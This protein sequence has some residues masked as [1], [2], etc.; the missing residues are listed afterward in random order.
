M[1]LA[2]NGLHFNE[3]RVLVTVAD[4]RGFGAAGQRL[5]LTQSAVSHSVRTAERKL[6]A[7]L[8]DRGR[9]GATPTEPGERAVA[10]ARQ[11]LRLL[12]GM[13]GEVRAAVSGEV[14]G[15]LRIASFRSAAAQVLPGVLERLRSRYPD[16]AAQVAIVPE[17]G[18][19]TAGEVAAGRADLGIAT[20]NEGNHDLPKGLLTGTI[21]EERYVLVH[22][23]GAEPRELR[24]IDWPENCSSYTRDW[25]SRQDWLPRATVTAE[26]DGVVLSMVAAGMGMAVVPELSMPG[27]PAGLV[28]RDLGADG[29]TRRVGYVTTPGAAATAGVRALIRELR[30][31]R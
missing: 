12:D 3:L 21:L 5:G 15:T 26:D 20:L 2:P 28:A 14:T 16:L 11:I 7:V 18:A 13:P 23:R 29:P 4:A 31:V 27:A 8:F 17:L 30:A 10:Q 19:G 1:S 6:G 22:P 24:L 25:W 9:H